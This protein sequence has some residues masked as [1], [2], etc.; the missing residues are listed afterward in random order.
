MGL[1]KAEFM[2]AHKVFRSS[3]GAAKYQKA[4]TTMQ[5]LESPGPK[6]I[7]ALV[8]IA[9]ANIWIPLVKTS[10]EYYDTRDPQYAGF[11]SALLDQLTTSNN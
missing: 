6:D 10:L 8:E 9:P 4:I 11:Y 7:S 5:E 2:A 3:I 1:S